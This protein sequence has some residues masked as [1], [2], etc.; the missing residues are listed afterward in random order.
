MVAHEL[1][2]YKD[3][4]VVFPVAIGIF[5]LVLLLL[6]GFLGRLRLANRRNKGRGKT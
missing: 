4:S 3:M 5:S 6:L 1:P 2:L